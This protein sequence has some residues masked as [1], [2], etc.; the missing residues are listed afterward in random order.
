MIGR[1]VEEEN[2]VQRAATAL[3]VVVAMLILWVDDSAHAVT[4]GFDP[5]AA[6]IASGGSLPLNLQA[7][8]LGGTPTSVIGGFDLFVSW[9]PAVL[10][11]NAATLGSALGTIPAQAITAITPTTASVELF[12][13]SLLDPTSL[14]ALQ[15][16]TA[17][18]ANLSWNVLTAQTSQVSISGLVSDALGNALSVQFQS[19]QLIPVPEPDTALLFVFGFLGFVVM[20]FKQG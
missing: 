6:T 7:T 16:G 4:I 13:N 9:D 14:A 10:N 15:N 11:F 5:S 19:A 3:M 1:S 2:Y 12:E 18:L 17:V 8:G 20:K